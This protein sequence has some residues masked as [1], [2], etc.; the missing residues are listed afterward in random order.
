[1]VIPRVGNP[2]NGHINPYYIG[3]FK[4]ISFSPRTLG[5]HDPSLTSIFVFLRFVETN[6]LVTSNWQPGNVE[7]L[8]VFFHLKLA[9]NHYK[10]WMCHEFSMTR[11]DNLGYGYTPE[12]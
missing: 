1:M 7:N 12:R 3:G 8:L 10:G 11:E 2:Y 6:Q 9:G 5:I 4:E